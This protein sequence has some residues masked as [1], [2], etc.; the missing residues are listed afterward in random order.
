MLLFS[1]CETANKPDARE[2][3][4]EQ[5]NPE[6][7]AVSVSRTIPFITGLQADDVSEILYFDDSRAPGYAAETYTAKDEIAGVIAMLESIR[8]ERDVTEQ[9]VTTSAPGDFCG[10]EIHMN[11]GSIYTIRRSGHELLVDGK[12]YEFSGEIKKQLHKDQVVI[13]AEC[14]I[15]YTGMAG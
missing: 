14:S 5:E 12:R 15:G 10:Y 11:N 13:S 3:A 2:S 6:T 7:P 8:L 9:A 1:G 4:A